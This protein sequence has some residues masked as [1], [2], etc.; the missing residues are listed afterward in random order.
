MIFQCRI[1]PNSIKVCDNDIYWVV[2]E[3]SDIRPY[4]I[5]LIKGEEHKKNYPN[6][7]EL[8]G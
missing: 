3:S 1:N 7:I 5:I 2:N 4:G 8:Y 6:F